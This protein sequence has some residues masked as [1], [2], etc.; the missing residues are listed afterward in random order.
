M[1][2]NTGDHL[3]R[4][5]DGGRAARRDAVRVSEVTVH[6]IEIG[7]PRHGRRGRI[8]MTAE[9]ERS[10]A[11]G[12][13]RAAGCRALLGR[14]FRE[15]E[16]AYEAGQW[17]S[18]DAARAR[19]WAQAREIVAAAYGSSAFY[20]ERLDAAGGVDASPEG[21]CR[22][23]P[24]T[25]D[26]IARHAHEITGPAR[27]RGFTRT[28]GGSGGPG[29]AIPIDRATYAWYV[30]GT[31]RGFSW[32]GVG[33]ADRVAVLL[34]R[35]RASGLH[36]ALGAAKDRVVGWRRVPVND[37]FD[38]AAAAALE[39]VRAWEPVAL[40]GYPSAVYRLVRAGRPGERLL[41][42]PPRVVVL[43]GEPAYAFQRRRIEEA[44]GCPVA[45][46]YGM[47]ELGCVAFA[48]PRGALHVSSESVLLEAV[49]A[50]PGDAG[51]GRSTAAGA[52]EGRLLATHL[53]NRLFPL[54]RYDTG[55]AGS[56]SE[57]PCPCGRGLP[58]LHVRGRLRDAVAEA[59]GLVPPRQSLERFFTT[60]PEPLKGRVRVVSRAV[61][62]AVVLEVER[63][64]GSVT[65]DPARAAEVA[66]DEFGPTWRVSA[67]YVDRF[68]RLPS[69]KL[70][71]VSVP[72]P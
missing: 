4:M 29:A 2:A 71:Y 46:E 14:T 48:C 31:W 56:L 53:R 54:I 6:E 50:E 32:W 55:D 58:I 63:Y 28:S 10:G 20:R 42:T 27:R 59:A 9:R 3:S 11:L 21:F 68:R 22:I 61:P 23:P 12:R 15:A 24:L 5:E 44:L 25:K 52:G 45:E 41:R 70:A 8:R 57:M 35:S 39:R 34:G 65:T 40:Y 18:R 64:D 1:Y 7:A 37:E 67:V 47:G 49:P 19:Q 51:A 62:G 17:L 66:M 13:L 33:L 43:T 72:S 38:G 60:L 30:A 16:A 26:E 36:A 69:G